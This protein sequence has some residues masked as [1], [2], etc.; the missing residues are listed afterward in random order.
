MRTLLAV[1]PGLFLLAIA[2]ACDSGPGPVKEPPVLKVTSPARGTYNGPAGQVVV[3]GT[4]EPGPSGDAVDKVLVNNVEA[5]VGADGTF[6]AQIQVDEGATLIQTVARGA[7]GAT[8][9]DTRAIE[10]GQMHAVGSD[11]PGAITAALSTDTFARISAAAG[12]MLKG[13]DLNALIAPLQPVA[14]WDDPNGEDCKFARVFIDDLQLS[15]VAISLSPVQN[16]LAFR[17][18]IDKLD[19]SGHARYAL[20]CITLENDVRITADKIVVAGT[21]NVTPNGASGFTTKLANPDVTLTGFHISA[22]PIPD[23]LIADLHLDSAISFVISKVAE[24]AMNPLMNQA[25]G[26]LAGPQRLDVAGK[27]LDMQVAPGTLSFAPDGAVVAMSLKVMLGGSESSPGFIFTD[28]GA[29]AMDPNAGLQLGVADDLVNEMLAELQATGVLDLAIP[30]PGG[31]FDTAQVKMTLP[32]MISAD[33]SDGALRL[34]LPD[35]IATFTSHGTPV[36]KAAI[37]AR[38]DL[39]ATP[40]VSGS[41]VALQLGQPDIHIDV[42]DDVANTTGFGDQELATATSAVIAAQIDTVTPLLGA[43]PLPSIAGISLQ[44]V[45]LTSD[46]GYVMLH[47]QLR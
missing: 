41:G 11:I 34:V 26:A 45:S 14:H 16:G 33:A 22:S 38:L 37:N 7:N 8:A 25:L 31:L 27:Q 46:S 17:A 4:V 13:L 19:V 24:I 39:K 30:V 6:R 10:A 47:A 9:T 40:T 15:D 44:N 18:E 23:S 36:A 21:L 12:P 32:P 35:V 42:L 29:P 5:A 20:A 2:P 3:S 28:N 1:S 43:I